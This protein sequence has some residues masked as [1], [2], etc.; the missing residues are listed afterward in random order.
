MRRATAL[1]LSTLLLAAPARAEEGREDWLAA[2]ARAEEDFNAACEA[3][4]A[5][6][7]PEGLVWLRLGPGGIEIAPAD[8][9]AA[10][11][12]AFWAE[13][14]LGARAAAEALYGRA[15]GEGL[16]A[17]PVMIETGPDGV[18]V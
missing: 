9:N 14:A 3:L 18:A 4:R 6:D 8:E 2:V 10:A 11:A 12:A 15:S 5:A 1:A 17:A 16:K 7:P 13:A